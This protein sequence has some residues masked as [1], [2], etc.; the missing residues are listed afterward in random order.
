MIVIPNQTDA[1]DFAAGGFQNVGTM[2]DMRSFYEEDDPG[3][4]FAISGPVIYNDFAA[5]HLKSDDVHSTRIAW[6]KSNEQDFI[7][8]IE[9]PEII[10]KTLRR[11]NDGYYSATHIVKVTHATCPGNAFMVVAISL[12]KDLPAECSFHQITTI[13]NKETK[14]IF[15][16][17]GTIRDKYKYAQ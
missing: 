6:I 8:A 1:I 2:P 10:E 11:R 12:S 5:N 9:H 4:K 13:H 3:R 17:D 16:K 7:R 15:K 14:D